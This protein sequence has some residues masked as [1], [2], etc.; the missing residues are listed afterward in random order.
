MKYIDEVQGDIVTEEE[1]IERLYEYIEYDDMR[2]TLQ[3]MRFSEIFKNLSEEFQLK[4]YEETLNR[5]IEEHYYFANYDDE[6][7]DE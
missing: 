2:E 7:E 5:L 1:M 6:E 3:S 4:I